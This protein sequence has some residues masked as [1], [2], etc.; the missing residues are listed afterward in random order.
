LE[1]AARALDGS[2]SLLL[3]GGTAL[4]ES[5]LV[6]AGKIAAQTGCKILSEW[7]NARMER[8]AGRVEIGRV[9]Y[10]IDIALK[11]LEPFKR[12]VLIGAR[13]PIGFFAYPG[14]PAILTRDDAE[15]VTLADAG[16]NLASALLAL[17]DATSATDTPPAHVAVADIPDRPTGTITLDTLAQA[18]A[19]AIPEDGIIVDESVTTGRAFFPVTK[20]A[21]KHTWLNNCG[22]SIGYG[23]PAAIG[24]AVACPDRKVMSLTGDGSAMYTVQAL[25]TMARENL[26]ITV[27]IF[28]N[29]SYQILRGELTNVGVG[30]PGPRAID[31]LSL[32]RPALDWVQMAGSMGVEACRVDACE[33]LEAALNTGLSMSGPYLIQIDL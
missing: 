22:G 31:M 25:W 18:I 8:G 11:V 33:D 10:P 12:I 24:A 16:A 17:T 2:D 14:K 5:N 13:A 30:N 28:A 19:R 20:G 32:D 15:I 29:R 4:T 26:D 27:L 7:S 1:Q 6:M 3:L 21:P 9:P 23:M